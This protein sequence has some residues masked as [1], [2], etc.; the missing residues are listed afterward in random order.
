MQNPNKS[1]DCMSI[2]SAVWYIEA[3]LNYTYCYSTEEKLD[4]D[5]NSITLDS[6]LIN[7]E[8]SENFI[9]LNNVT[10]IYNNFKETITYEFNQIKNPVKFYDFVDIAYT[11]NKFKAYFTFNTHND[12]NNNK[13]LIFWSSAP[14]IIYKKANRRVGYPY[15]GSGYYTDIDFLFRTPYWY[16]ATNNNPYGDY[17]LFYKKI[18]TG[19][20]EPYLTDAEMNYYSNSSVDALNIAKND[21]PS[22]YTFK[23]WIL[24]SY[25]WTIYDGY[26]HL[27]HYMH[28]YYGNLHNSGGQSN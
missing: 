7:Y 2:D 24:D 12:D 22:G 15:I 8:N 10:D 4:A 17:L 27:V 14:P 1:N 11:N 21:I 19:S 26:D 16:F 5:L 18:I 3:A 20:P 9:S 23:S 25:G 28:V 13:S 6:L